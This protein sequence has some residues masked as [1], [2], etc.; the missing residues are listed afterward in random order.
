[1]LDLDGELYL[2]NLIDTPG[3][4]DFHYEVS[5]SMA[6]CEGAVLLVDAV[7][8]V[9]AQTVANYFL[10]LQHNLKIIPVVNKIDLP[11]A[12]VAETKQQLSANFD[13]PVSSVLSVSAASRIG[14]EDIFLSIV[15]QIPPP[16]SDINKPLK[17]LL[18]DSWYG[19]V[20]S[21]VIC[22]I[23]LV[24]GQLKTGDLIV[25]AAFDKTY[26]V[27]ELGIMHPE[28]APTAAL[29]A[30]QVGYVKL[31]MKTTQEARVGDTFYKR[32]APVEPLP[33]FKSA[34]P[35]V[36]AG[37]YPDDISDFNRLREAV[38]KLHLTDASVTLVKETKYGET[39]MRPFR[40]SAVGFY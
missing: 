13:I 37:I 29:Y 1:M 31:G 24:D 40:F 10:A 19:D 30:G 14:L 7:K 25:S 22:L 9:Q 3:H 32:D 33:G 20:F 15:E 36:W 39:S 2:L 23:K 38:E 17:A 18:F 11:T 4:V 27:A 21:G 34:K 12:Q 26:E 28:Q 35:M 16:S 8:G 6:A 5:R